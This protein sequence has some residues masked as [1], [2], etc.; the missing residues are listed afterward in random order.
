MC[1]TKSVTSALYLDFNENLG[2]DEQYLKELSKI[3]NSDGVQFGAEKR[4][5]ELHKLI[6]NC[7]CYTFVGKVGLF[8]PMLPGVGG[9][10]LLR[11][12][13]GKY[14][15]ATGAKGYR[16]MEAEMVKN[17]GLENQID[18]SYYDRMVDEAIKTIEQFGD[19]EMFVNDDTHDLPF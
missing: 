1:E 4:A 13:D 10:V 7:H 6:D 8:C 5:E 14:Y 3:E 9:G 15:S 2:D 17:L 12:K 16:W 11:E 19:Y 18:R